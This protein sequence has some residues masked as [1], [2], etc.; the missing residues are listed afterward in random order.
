MPFCQL[1]EQNGKSWPEYF[2]TCKIATEKTPQN[3]HNTFQIFKVYV[4]KL[5]K[6][7]EIFLK[8]LDFR[9]CRWMLLLFLF[10]QYSVAESKISGSI[11]QFRQHWD[12]I[13]AG[14]GQHLGSIEQYFRKHLGRIE[15]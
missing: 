12:R 3:A 9:G 2:A 8:W 14:F 13:W 10:R 5:E 4:K 11:T 15:I 6:A 7:Q 1:F